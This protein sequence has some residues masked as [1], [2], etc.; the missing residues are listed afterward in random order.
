MEQDRVGSHR[1]HSIARKFS[2]A[3]V[4]LALGGSSA[5]ADATFQQVYPQ[6]SRVVCHIPNS[7]N[8][9]HV[10]GFDVGH[11][12]V[13][14]GAAYWATGDLVVDTNGNGQH[15]EYPSPGSIGR[16]TDLKASDC[17][18]V[19]LRTTTGADTLP[20][21]P[22]DPSL[23]ECTIWAA[24]P[25]EAAGTLYFFYASVRGHPSCTT[26]VGGLGMIGNP[27]SGEL[28][29]SRV[30]YGYDYELSPVKDGGR[31]YFFAQDDTSILMA[32]VSETLVTTLS[33]YEYWNG[34]AWVGAAQKSSAAP[35]VNLE[36]GDGSTTI[37]F[38]DYTGRY[39]LVY[40]CES[41][42][43]I[44]V[45]TAHQAGL[46]DAALTSGW[47]DPT[48]LM[49]ALYAGHAFWHSGYKDATHPEKIY[50]S[51]ARFPGRNY[52]VTIFEVDL[53]PEP[54]PATR[55]IINSSIDFQTGEHGWSYVSYDPQQP[56]A[57]LIALTTPGASLPDPLG[58]TLPGWVG[59]E[60]VSMGAAPGVFGSGAWPSETRGAGRAWTAPSNGTVDL[61]GEAWVESTAGDDAFAEVLIVRGTQVIHTWSKKIDADWQVNRNA[62]LNKTNVHVVAGDKV[63]FGIR[64]GNTVASNAIA[65]LSYFLATI[66]YDPS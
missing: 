39:M 9:Q 31:I 50:L 23:D 59:S 14:N 32:R 65:D 19:K 36:S 35:I 8:D 28:A 47:N 6:A 62:L 53:G 63:V 40:A 30:G 44:C 55:Q 51:T 7:G 2:L 5:A 10:I 1:V 49:D 18:D 26:Y 64:K 25:F 37:A 11:S 45:R 29:P 22:L 42:H 66:V 13:Y 43:K 12:F 20:I 60:T 4:L 33:A 46:G 54:P 3:V 56:G 24:R 41:Y 15:G 57:G 16:T 21:L 27:S 34:S 48:V 17:V 58:I 38:N 52:F 61:S